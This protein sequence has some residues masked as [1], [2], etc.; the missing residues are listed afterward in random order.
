MFSGISLATVNTL[1][2]FMVE[3]LKTGYSDDMAWFNKLYFVQV[4]GKDHPDVAK[5][6]NNLAL[7]C[8]NQN[9]FDEVEKFYKRALQIYENKFGPDDANVAKTKNHL[10]SP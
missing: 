4:Y 1:V 2:A 9:K 3:H 5:Q 8:Q 7:L 10:V 6:L